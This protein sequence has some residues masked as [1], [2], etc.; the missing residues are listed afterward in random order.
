MQNISIVNTAYYV[1]VY[2]DRQLHDIKQICCRKDDAVPLATDTTF[3]LCDLRLTNTSYRNKRLLNESTG[4]SPVFLGPCIL[5][6]MKKHLADLHPTYVLE[7]Q[8][9]MISNFRCRHGISN[10]Q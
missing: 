3:S 1:F 10:I 7:I 9:W 6:K 4:T 5:Q 8:D 2:R